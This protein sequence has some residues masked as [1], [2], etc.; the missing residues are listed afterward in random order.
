[1]SDADQYRHEHTLGEATDPRDVNHPEAFEEKPTGIHI[2]PSKFVLVNQLRS[3]AI[4]GPN[5]EIGIAFQLKGV[6]NQSGREVSITNVAPI[7]TVARIVAQLIEIAVSTGEENAKAFHAAM[8]E[9]ME[10]Q[11]LNHQA[12]EREQRDG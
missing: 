11:A 10:L 8:S 7:E 12:Y 3:S 4:S 1:M 5:D 6:V 9:E 2:D